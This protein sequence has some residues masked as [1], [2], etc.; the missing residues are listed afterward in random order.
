MIVWVGIMDGEGGYYI[1]APRPL[2][3]DLPAPMALNI[4]LTEQ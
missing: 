1:L 2:R 3:H 4:K